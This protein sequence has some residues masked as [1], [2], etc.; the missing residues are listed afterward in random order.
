MNAPVSDARQGALVRAILS[1]LVAVAALGW[2]ASASAVEPD[3]AV[4]GPYEVSHVDYRG[5]KVALTLPKGRKMS[6]S[7]NQPLR[8]SVTYPA[9][10]E[11][12]PVV[13]FLH[14]RH[15]TCVDRKGE[16]FIPLPGEDNPNCP[17]RIGGN[18]KPVERWIR[19]YD[20]YRYLAD[21]LASQ[22]YLVISADANKIA[23][24]EYASARAGIRARYQLVGATLDLA[25]RWGAGSEELVPEEKGL[26]A[27]TDLAGRMD[28]GHIALMG[29]SRGGDAVNQFI[30]FNQKRSTVYPLD[31]VV[32]IGPT[33]NSAANPFRNGGTNLAEILPACDGDVFDLQ[34]GHVFERVK[35]SLRGRNASKYQWLVG[36]TNHN[37]F[38]TIWKEDDGKYSAATDLDSACGRQSPTS[39]RLG[40]AEQRKAGLALVNG[41]IRTFA[42]GESAFEPALETGSG[43]PG[44][45]ASYIAPLAS[46]RLII[47]PGRKSPTGMNSLGGTIRKR[48]LSLG[49][50]DAT[51]VKWLKQRK[52]CP[53]FSGGDESTVNRS[54]TRQLVVEWKRKSRITTVI[55]EASDDASAYRDLVFRAV[56]TTSG[57]NPAPF[58]NQKVADSTQRLDVVMVD[59]LGYSH[60]VPA[61]AY[62]SALNPT[63][64]D[65]TRQLVLSDVRIPLADF[66]GV[67]LADLASIRL[68]FGNRGRTHGQIQVADL[69]FQGSV[70]PAPLSIPAD[71]NA[72]PLPGPGTAVDAI[73]TD[74]S[75]GS[76]LPASGCSGEPSVALTSGPEVTGDRLLLKGQLRSPGCEARV[77]VSLFER[78]GELCRYFTPAGELGQAVDCG[79][80]YS[81]IPAVDDG[82]DWMISIPWTDRA[83]VPE[84]SLAAV[85]L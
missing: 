81:L 15:A 41:F 64:G 85:A 79:N 47:G 12:W 46:R 55:P 52:K 29:H 84:V 16:N 34:G 4:P 44:V 78:N 31:G 11:N 3:P 22:G 21:R 60:S 69:A 45:K 28:L 37:W 40:R 14:G 8:G 6:T 56:T 63:V 51:E 36:G 35:N 27:I 1:I 48:G 7:F 76:S 39:V 32:A 9:S 61:E 72:R 17:D 57:R 43:A 5:G 13:V 42:G 75:P 38:N 18:G 73:L 74:V 19:S 70:V 20:G 71:R 58:D 68:E 67:N 83:P 65:R 82:G 26:P 50:C 80:P 33:D 77:Q 2:V 10:G 54:W 62:S 53:G 59:H 30:A 66:V 49:W 24:Y 25:R 23:S